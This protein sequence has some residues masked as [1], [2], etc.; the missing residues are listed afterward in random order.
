MS[1]KQSR[2]SAPLV[3]R[4]TARELEIFASMH[5]SHVMAQACTRL[6]RYACAVIIVGLVSWGVV[7][8]LEAVAGKITLAD[9]RA[10]L[11]LSTPEE[12]GTHGKRAIK[13]ARMLYEVLTPIFGIVGIWYARRAQKREDDT[14]IQFA[15]FRQMHEAGIDVLRT[16]SGL[17]IDGRTPAEERS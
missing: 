7:H 9:I 2:G 10:T 3:H 6:G 8:S 16:T 15:P 1:N 11:S 17:D 4:Y 14:V 13:Y 12:D 5:R